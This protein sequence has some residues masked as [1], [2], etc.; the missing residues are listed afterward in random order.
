MRKWFK[1]ENPEVFAMLADL[2]IIIFLGRD[3]YGKPINPRPKN[4]A[5][6]AF[7]ASIKPWERHGPVR[8]EVLFQWRAEPPF[9]GNNSCGQIL[10]RD[11]TFAEEC[12]ARGAEM[13]V[14]F[15]WREEHFFRIAT[16]HF[17]PTTG[18]VGLSMQNRGNDAKSLAFGVAR[19]QSS[20][21]PFHRAWQ[22]RAGPSA[23]T[24]SNW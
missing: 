6:E 11:I 8:A 18:Q 3:E 5:A 20:R 21:S 2:G 16:R 22:E 24:V 12:N 7:F 4:P 9:H 10:A 14:S 15:G 1:D 23:G 17:M 13:L 19:S